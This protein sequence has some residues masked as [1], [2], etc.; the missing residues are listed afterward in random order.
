MLETMSQVSH[1]RFH[2]KETRK[3]RPNW[4]ENEENNNH[5]KK[6]EI[7]DLEFLGEN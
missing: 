3:R 7:N 1:L 6:A 5:N 2:L 4:I